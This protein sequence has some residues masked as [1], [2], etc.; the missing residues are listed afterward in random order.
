MILHLEENLLVVGMTVMMLCNKDYE[1]I[2]E[3]YYVT[4]YHQ[5]KTFV[6]QAYMFKELAACGYC[7]YCKCNAAVTEHKSDVII[8]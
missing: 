8:Q 7:D 4:R 1:C 5:F 2:G 3:K 6:L